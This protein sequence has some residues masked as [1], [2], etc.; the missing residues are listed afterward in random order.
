MEQI[1]E[2]RNKPT[3]L[4][5]INTQQE[6]STYNGLKAVYSINGAGEIGQIHTEK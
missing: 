5:T 2:P 4:E 6:A 1:R 3:P